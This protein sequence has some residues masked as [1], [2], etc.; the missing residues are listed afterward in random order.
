MFVQTDF[1]MNGEGR[2]EFGSALAEMR[3]DPGLLRPYFDAQGNKV[4]TRTVL[5][6]IS[7]SVK[8]Y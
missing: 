7:M 4:C 1:I 3:F 8:L 2:G 5:L 6:S